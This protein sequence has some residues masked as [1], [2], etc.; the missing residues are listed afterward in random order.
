MV[1]K[2]FPAADAEK[3]DKLNAALKTITEGIAN[4]EISI[5]SKIGAGD[6]YK[7]ITKVEKTSNPG[8]AVDLAHTAGEVWLLDFWATWCP[9]CQGPMAH[10]VKMLEENKDAWGGKV[11]IIGLSI[12]KDS[13]TVNKHVE[14]KG[15]GNV[16]HYWR[17]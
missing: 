15:W 17:A 6:P 3:A 4:V 16:E 9:P 11:R 14:A 8:E 10:N 13:E 12:D 5:V 2:D 1:S 7:T